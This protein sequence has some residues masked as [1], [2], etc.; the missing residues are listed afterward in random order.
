MI[1]VTILTSSNIIKLERLVNC[2]NQQTCK[3]FDFNIVVNTLDKNYEQAVLEKYGDIVTATKSN[4][5]PGRGKN[6]VVKLWRFKYPGY[7]YYS[8]IDGDDLVYPTFVEAL[9]QHINQYPNT[10]ALGM[11]CMDVIQPNYK[12]ECWTGNNI[13]LR[14]Q[15]EIADFYF[16]ESNIFAH[17]RLILFSIR[18]LDRVLFDPYLEVYEDYLLSLKLL[19]LYRMGE[20]EYWQ[21][22][23][24]DM[25]IYDKS[26]S[27]LTSNL[28]FKD[29][30]HYVVL[31]RMKAV[32][33]CHYQWSSN[34][35]VLYNIPNPILSYEER[36]AFGN[37]NM[38]SLIAVYSFGTDETKCELLKK[39]AEHFGYN[40]TIE[41]IGQ[42]YL[43]HG[44]KIKNFKKFCEA[45]DPD[46]VVMFVD[47]YDVIF[48]QPPEVLYNKWQ[49]LFDNT[50]VF[51]AETNC[52]PDVELADEYPTPE[53][54]R[55]KFLNS[56]VYMGRAKDVLK[57][58][59]EELQDTYDDQRYFVDKFLYNNPEKSISLDYNT[60]LF[61]PICYAVT[62]VR[63][64]LNGL[65]NSE[66]NTYP[67]LL[68]ANFT[69]YSSEYLETFFNLI[70]MINIPTGLPSQLQGE[71]ELLKM[72]NYLKI[73]KNGEASR[74]L[75]DE[76]K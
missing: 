47:A 64:D 46:T 29:W 30:A 75:P 3:D 41:G 40:L 71:L 44:L 51:N 74:Y 6:S 52:H 39:S 54:S 13:D 18:I 31:L 33:T 63:Y 58:L 19:Q 15:N 61:M 21:T 42:N 27:S 32:R 2:L 59:P 10:D 24:T 16:Q 65:Y 62:S 66:I 70:T 4:G 45:Q 5:S 67:C 1:L 72:N 20:I 28:D 9:Y 69:E 14:S 35:N 34:K 55:F 25:Y 26:G 50:V 60:E 11:V 12:L 17:D 68:H 37:K 23:S 7:D 73:F 56:G 38:N 53:N 36:L 43:G 49:K 76:K 8:L 57:L 48:V 22:T